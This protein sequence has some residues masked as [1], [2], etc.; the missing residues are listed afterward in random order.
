MAAR[1]Q[2][3]REE[4]VKREKALNAK[5]MELEEERKQM[6]VPDRLEFNIDGFGGE[7]KRSALFTVEELEKEE[8]DVP[9]YKRKVENI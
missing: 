7:G 5:L 4:A 1:I 3:E 2:R 9:V 8:K 6:S